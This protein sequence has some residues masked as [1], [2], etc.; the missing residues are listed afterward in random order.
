M[1]GGDQ[2]SHRSEAQADLGDVPDSAEKPV[3]PTPVR[4]LGGILVKLDDRLGQVAGGLL[5]VAPQVPSVG[6][7]LLEPCFGS[8]HRI[9]APEADLTQR[10]DVHRRG[11]GPQLPK[12]SLLAICCTL[13]LER[14]CLPGFEQGVVAGQVLAEGLKGLSAAVEPAGQILE[15]VGKGV[16]VATG[17]IRRADRPSSSPSRC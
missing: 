13:Q 8:S 4:F 15:L 11:R 7:D 2:R 5:E 17:P 16:G 12:R 1:N 10:A 3:T 6:A 9:I 14:L